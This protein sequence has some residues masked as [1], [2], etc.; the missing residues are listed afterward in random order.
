MNINLTY[1]KTTVAVT[2]FTIFILFSAKATS[3]CVVVTNGT[4]VPFDGRSVEGLQ[5]EKKSM[6]LLNKEFPSLNVVE[7]TFK[8][9]VQTCSLCTDKYVLCN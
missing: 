3:A 5:V 9:E 6:V 4:K 2:F 7:K 8:G 1:S